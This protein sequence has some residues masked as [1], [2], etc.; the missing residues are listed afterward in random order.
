[1][2]RKLIII[3]LLF[4]ASPVWA[5]D[6]SSSINYLKSRQLD[7]W[8][9]MALASAGQITIAANIPALS[10]ITPTEY[11]K[12]ILALIAA[13]QNPTNWAGR[14]FV[15]EFLDKYYQSSQLGDTS[16]LNDDFWGVVALSAVQK[17]N[18][19]DTRSNTAL[20]DSKNYI[21]QNQKADGGW[22]FSRLGQSDS[23]DT[24]AAI[25]ALIDAG[26][27]PSDLAIQRA[28]NF[29]KTLQKPDGGMAFSIEFSSDGD[30]DGWVIMA[31]NKAGIDP[32]SWRKN[33][34]LKDHLLSLKNSDGS[35]SWKAGQPGGVTTTSHAVVALSGKSYPIVS[36][37]QPALVPAPAPAPAPT[38]AFVPVT[39][40]TPTSALTILPAP[41]SAPSASAPAL[42]HTPTP[43][44]APV[45]LLITPT[46]PLP[47]S[48]PLSTPVLP[49]V[50]LPPDVK[51][52]PGQ[53]WLPPLAVL[54]NV[55]PQSAPENITPASPIIPLMGAP[56]VF[57]PAPIIANPSQPEPAPQLPFPATTVDL[58]QQNFNR[59]DADKDGLNHAQELLHGTDPNNKDT[60]GDGFKDG[61]EVA[62]GFDPLNPA[63]CKIEVNP[64]YSW[65]YNQKRLKTPSQ[66]RCFSN[67]LKKQL[68]G[69]K[70][71]T[72]NKKPWPDVLNAFIY[73]HYPSADIK[74]W[75]NGQNK[76]SLTVP[77]WEFKQ[78]LADTK[79]IHVANEPK[80]QK[81]DKQK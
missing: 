73:G 44:P 47:A 79:I 24:A 78:Y 71:Q 57:M 31:L 14:N 10:T 23:N 37:F 12:A 20:A 41:T 7:T 48:A 65:Y 45:P 54:I 36:F 81:Y 77:K 6:L 11:E 50:A 43:T 66:E 35:F 58:T 49:S 28:L 72:Q 59:F 4:I 32:A 42:A 27:S 5:L 16:L 19:P 15:K 25:L 18:L 13:G 55:I 62:N 21:I 70:N 63:P 80:A 52:Q 40:Q 33:A 3:L 39:S 51:L 22:S 46:A 75:L 34:S 61:A 26:L 29:L 64:G 1:M 56:S 38:L 30:S 60:D 9:I 74:D 8:S 2:I 68:S 53:T 17:A 76:V 67:Y 69:T